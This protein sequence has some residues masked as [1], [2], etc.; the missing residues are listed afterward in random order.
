M[1]LRAGWKDRSK[2]KTLTPAES[3]E[4]FFYQSGQKANKARAFCRDGCPVR[5]EC[6]NYALLY[7]EEGVW[8][9]TTDEE[10]N[11]L[12][13]IRE[14]LLEQTPLTQLE[15]RNFRA[16]LAVELGEEVVEVIDS[17]E[18][19]TV[20]DDGSLEFDLF[21]LEPLQLIDGSESSTSNNERLAG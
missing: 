8:A 16:W 18:V 12:T 7:K 1:V 11:S 2:C 6:L 5:Q 3:D 17:I 13:M 10:R 4:L 14:M 19:D 15:N 9:G 20:I 21:L